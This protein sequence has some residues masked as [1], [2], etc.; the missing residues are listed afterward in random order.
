ME[1]FD[2]ATLVGT[3]S[4]ADPILAPANGNQGVIGTVY[5]NAFS[6]L[7]FDTIVGSSTSFAF[8]ADNAAFGNVPEPGTLTLFGLGL[9]GLG[10]LRRRRAATSA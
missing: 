3:I 8:E 7:L 5:L 6:T 1:F 10:L 2:G 4:G 9:I